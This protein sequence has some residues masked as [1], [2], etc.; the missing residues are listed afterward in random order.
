MFW[1]FC[2][3]D[4]E[5]KAPS[6]AVVV[7][8]N[9]HAEVVDEADDPSKL[10]P[11]AAAPAAVAAASTMEARDNADPDSKLPPEDED[12]WV[13]INKGEDGVTGLIVETTGD[14]VFVAKVKDNLGPLHEWN[15]SAPAEQKVC[16]GDRILQ[17][18][19]VIGTG[20]GLTQAMK[21]SQELRM[22]VRHPKRLTIKL[23][24]AGRGLGI[25][26]NE[27]NAKIEMLRIRAVG[28]GVLQDWNNDNPDSAIQ[29]EDRIVKVNGVMRDPEAMLKTL[30][31][32]SELELEIVRQL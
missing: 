13:T 11:T 17:V 23:E 18:N 5:A 31:E 16:V 32:S 19:D 2:C 14:I 6:H 24:K 4:S 3:C 26:L 15:A 20:P 27:V 9:L 10:Q 8:E 21:E 25:T 29:V 30:K 28:K 7:T 1:S 12:F 22:R